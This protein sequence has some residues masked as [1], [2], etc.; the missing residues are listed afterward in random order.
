MQER[1]HQAQQRAKEHEK[2]VEER[3][4]A[5]I[6]SAYRRGEITK[7]GSGYSVPSYLFVE[8]CITMVGGVIEEYERGLA[9]GDQ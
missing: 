3:K 6:I 5:M 7:Q 4:K 2:Q 8:G 9:D 1:L